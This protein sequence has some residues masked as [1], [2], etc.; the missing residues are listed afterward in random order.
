MP[1]L[2]KCLISDNNSQNFGGGVY[3][4]S[5]SPVILDCLIINNV[6]TGGGGIWCY[7]QSNPEISNTVICGNVSD[8][9][10]GT[11]NDNGGNTVSDDCPLLCPDIS[12]DGQVD[13]TDLLE[14]ISDW[15]LFDSPA[16]VTNDGVVNV[17][18]LLSI[19]SNWGPCE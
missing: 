12:G 19:I 4:S 14:V 10:N 11:W 5:S 9:I 2:D 8:Q 7:Y 18:D 13:I 16:D 1:T 3:C 6:A 15:G 17:S